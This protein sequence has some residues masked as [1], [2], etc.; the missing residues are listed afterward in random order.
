MAK[1]LVTGGAGFIG[2]HLTKKLLN[3]GHQVVVLDNL[4][5]GKKENI[6]DNAQFIHDDIL[7]Q[8]LIDELIPKV[9]ACF[10]LAA[11]ASVE[12]CR[13]DWV[14]AHKTNITGTINILNAA[15]QHKTPVVYASSSAIYGDNPHLP[16]KESEPPRPLSSYAADKLACEHHA[17]VASHLFGIPTCGLRFFNVYGPDQDP[18]SPYS[19]VISI[20]MKRAFENQSI[21]IYGDGKQTR[22]FIYVADV[23]KSLILTLQHINTHARVFNVGTGQQQSLLE[24]H[25]II[26]KLTG[27]TIDIEFKPAREG[28]VKHSCANPQKAEKDLSFKSEITLEQGLKQLMNS[29]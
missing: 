5:T 26:E 12:K 17:Y 27:R 2:S 28:D 18:S 6:A 9:D 16:L 14:G 11:I 22:D 25:K 4:S 15:R 8:P 24:L 3:N 7:N 21:T 19:G 10:H 29:L 23:V 1:Y 13:Q 20:F